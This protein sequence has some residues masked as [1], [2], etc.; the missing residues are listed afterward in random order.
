MQ[1]VLTGISLVAAAVAAV[2]WFWASAIRIPDNIDKFIAALKFASRLNAA[3][4]FA[5]GIAS[6][7]AIA[8]FSIAPPSDVISGWGANE[9]TAF[10]TILLAFLTLFLIVVGGFQVHQVRKEGRNNRTLSVCERYDIDPVLSQSLRRLALARSEEGDLACN[11][12]KYRFDV[13]TILNFLDSLA[14]GIDRKLYDEKIAR[15][16]YNQIIK[17]HYEQYLGP[18]CKYSIA[19]V[20][21]QDFGCLKRLYDRWCQD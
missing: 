13:I 1:N 7:A 17:Y 12:G 9:W 10:G 3:G 5:A 14:I 8:A 18:S 20:R 19:D 16:H 2:L 15:D 4:A 6:V 21:I 11:P